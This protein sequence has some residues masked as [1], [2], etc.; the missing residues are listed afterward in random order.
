MIATSPRIPITTLVILIAGYPSHASEP[1]P[2][3][4]YLYVVSPGVRD[5][6]DFGGAGILVF[7]I[8]AGHKFVKRIATPA[9]TEAK[10]RNIKGVCASAAT[11]RLYFS[12]PEKLY[13]VDL[14]REKTLWEVAPPNGC[15]RMSITPDG[16]TLYVP[17]FEKDSWNV[18]DAATG[19]LITSIITKSGAHNTV[20]SLDGSRMYLGG[21]KSPMLFVADTTSHEI[22]KQVGPFAGAVRPFVVNGCKTRAY[23]CVNGLLGFEVGDLST[24]K[25]LHRVEV[26]GF[27]QG[28]VKRHG[29]PSHGVGLT[30]DETEVWVVDAANERVHVFDNTSDPP[31]QKS[32]IRLREQPGWVTF[33]RD[34]RYAYPSTGE[35][36]DTTTKRIVA[37]LTDETGREVHSEKM[38]EIH[39]GDGKPVA[40]GD[41]FGV[42]RVAV[43]Y[44][45]GIGN[46]VSAAVVGELPLLHTTQVLPS[47]RGEGDTPVEQQLNAALGTLT[48]IIRASGGDPSAIL[49]LHVVASS[50]AV[51]DEVRRLIPKRYAADRVPPMTIVVG[52]LPDASALVGIDAVALASTHTPTVMAH[53]CKGIPQVR[54]PHAA[55]LPP[56]PKVYIA[57]QAEKGATPAE[58]AAK[59]IASLKQTLDW[60][61]C[62]PE[63]AVQ[64]KCFL[65]PI[66]A[67]DEVAAEFNKAFGPNRVPLVFVE[68]KSSLPIEIELIAQA[69]PAKPDAPAIE[70][71]TPPGMTASP[72]YSRVVRVNR[73]DLV[74]TAGLISSKAGTGEEEVLGI[75]DVLKSVTDAVGSDFRHLVKATY[76]VSEDDAS[77]QLNTLRPRFYDPKRPPSASK[78]IVPGVGSRDRGI[79]IDMIAVRK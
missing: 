65:T 28:M 46:E 5:Y 11:G 29:C 69:P 71:L 58:A 31:T 73:G 59:T 52:A 25:K 42:G 16:R 7:D 14:V 8:D 10:P 36:I 12:T 3:H 55:T 47:G 50:A 77:R 38:M 19:Q 48:E 62:H 63:G 30:P 40:A 44:H 34:G 70:F 4:R 17:S 18:L 24:G 2:I 20:V 39:V 75:F 41:Q 56:G 6:L 9:S 35:V 66:S 53:L 26:Q 37:K 51:A 45:R 60:L 72:V 33:S 76:Y 1:G 74:Y 54:G 22:V 13:C 64:A 67:A 61:G 23:V 57:G 43:Q 68:W 78:A 21:L 27:R 49:R 79:V 32:S 15:D